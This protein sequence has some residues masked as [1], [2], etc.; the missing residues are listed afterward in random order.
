MGRLY[1]AILRAK[2]LSNDCLADDCLA[3]DWPELALQW[4]LADWHGKA[5]SK[6]EVVLPRLVVSCAIPTNT[7]DAHQGVG[8]SSWGR[9]MTWLTIA[10]DDWL[11]RNDSAAPKED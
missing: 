8:E 9:A 7:H 2:C 5:D 3:N 4:C 10:N 11:T 1:M 6:L